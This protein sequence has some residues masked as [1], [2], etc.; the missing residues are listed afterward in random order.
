M[1]G[2]TTAGPA[3]RSTLQEWDQR[4]ADN[5]DLQTMRHVALDALQFE[6]DDAFYTYAR[7]HHLTVDEVVYYLNAYEAGGD[8][9]LEAIRN[10][11]IIPPR[12]GAA[13]HQK[14][15]QDPR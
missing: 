14:D 15:R 6:D 1:P 7:D 9:G 3:K 2:A 13:D 5:R 8:V 4:T 12:R 10:P 11:D